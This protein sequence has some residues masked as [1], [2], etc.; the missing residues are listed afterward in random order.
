MAHCLEPSLGVKETG[1]G[2]YTSHHRATGRKVMDMEG[3]GRIWKVIKQNFF[4]EVREDI[5]D[6][7]EAT[8]HEK[9]HLAPQEMCSTRCG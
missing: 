9:L 2:P 5:E 7:S 8:R 1:P 4:I 6:H 3:Y